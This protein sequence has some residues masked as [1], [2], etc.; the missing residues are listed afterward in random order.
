MV[1]Y[2]AEQL[3]IPDP[4]E[5]SDGDSDRI[6]DAL[7]DLL[8]RE[9]EVADRIDEEGEDEVDVLEA[10]EAERDALDRA[11]LSTIGMEDRVDELKQAVEALVNLRRE[12][13]GDETSVLVSRTEEKEVIDL[14]GVSEARESTRL[15]DF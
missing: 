13:S 11:V 4:R 8:D 3:P 5:L 12:G 10:K 6:R 14:E 9:A 2:E 15:T 7:Q 1:L